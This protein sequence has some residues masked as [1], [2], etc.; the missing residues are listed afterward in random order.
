[1][2]ADSDRKLSKESKAVLIMWTICL[3]FDVRFR[4]QLSCIAK[5]SLMR[6][7]MLDTRA[8]EVLSPSRFA[9]NSPRLFC[10]SSFLGS[11]QIRPLRS[12]SRLGNCLGSLLFFGASPFSFPT[13]TI[14]FMSLAAET[15]FLQIPPLGRASPP[16]GDS[17]SCL[18]FT[19]TGST[20]FASRLISITSRAW[21][22]LF[23]MVSTVIATPRLWGSVPK[24][25]WRFPGSSF[26]RSPRFGI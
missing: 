20:T 15:T 7:P 19:F 1:M 25:K 3:A 23:P 2:P 17:A 5:L 18:K 11:R 22:T 6:A 24:T 13:L 14:R 10:T 16:Q 4:S 8:L 26:L 9:P 12:L 21:A